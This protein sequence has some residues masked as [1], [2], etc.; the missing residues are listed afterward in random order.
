MRTRALNGHGMAFLTV[1]GRIPLEQKKG[2][3]TPSRQWRNEQVDFDL[4]DKWLEDLNEIPEIEIVSICGGHD[5]WRMP[6]I[7]FYPKGMS[8]AQEEKLV[9]ELRDFPG[10]WALR[11]EGNRKKMRICMASVFFAGTPIGNIWWSKA[12]DRINVAI[13]RAKQKAR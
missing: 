11:G 2:R 12:A 8:D 7:I 9:D 3:T 4:K 1:T 13:R 6:H 10:T 5:I